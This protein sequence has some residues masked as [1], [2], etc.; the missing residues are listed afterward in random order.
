ML[1]SHDKKVAYLQESMVESSRIWILSTERSLSG[2][3]KEVRASSHATVH[4]VSS[5]NKARNTSQ[6]SGG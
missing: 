1:H 6:C 3:G 4:S 5:G 2:S